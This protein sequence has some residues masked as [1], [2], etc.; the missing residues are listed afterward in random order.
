MQRNISKLLALL[1][2]SGIALAAAEV[3]HIT[4]FSVVSDS[5]ENPV[6]IHNAVIAAQ[7]EVIPTT[8]GV[9]TPGTHHE[10][11][12]VEVVALKMGDVAHIAPVLPGAYSVEQ[13][14]PPS[15]DGVHTRGVHLRDHVVEHVTLS[16]HGVDHVASSLSGRALHEGV[17][18]LWVHDPHVLPL[19]RDHLDGLVVLNPQGVVHVETVVHGSSRADSV[20]HTPIQQEGGLYPQAT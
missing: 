4:H 3:S 16:P 14:A 15:V 20:I 1:A 13:V 5:V 18:F 2:L 9:Y 10:S 19:P 11:H 7:A 8:F 12:S 6:S 17:S